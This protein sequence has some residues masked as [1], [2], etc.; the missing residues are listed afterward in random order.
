MISDAAS[1]DIVKPSIIVFEFMS[2]IDKLDLW[3]FGTW[4]TE[5]VDTN[6]VRGFS[7]F[8]GDSI[9][10]RI[11]AHRNTKQIEYYLGSDVESLY[12][13]ISACVVDYGTVDASSGHCRLT[14][15]AMRT[16][17][18]DDERWENLKLT[19]AFELRLVKSLIENDYDHRIKKK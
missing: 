5:P 18:M 14:L 17:D 2:D 13:R 15:T 10:V 11:N 1:I 9:Y 6:T 3:S 8:N 7:I 12:P 19:H 16:E 4:Q